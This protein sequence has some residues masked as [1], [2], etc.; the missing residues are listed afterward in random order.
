LTI[1]TAVVKEEQRVV[2]ILL[3]RQE[4]VPK[5]VV[6]ERLESHLAHQLFVVGKVGDTVKFG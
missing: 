4:K 5:V 6:R 2:V 1:L 3:A